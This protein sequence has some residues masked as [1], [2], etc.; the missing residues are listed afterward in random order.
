VVSLA[1]EQA[2]T[3][4]KRWQWELSS[5]YSQ[6]NNCGPTCITF[7]A[8]FYKDTASYGIETTRR[9]IN[10]MGPYNVN[11]SSVWGAPPNTP[12]NTWQQRDMLIK[13]GVG[14]E[15]RQI[16]VLSQLRD[17][18]GGGQRPILVGLLMEHVPDYIKDHSFDGWHAVVVM[19]W[20][21]RNGQSGFWIMDPNFHPPSDGYRVDPDRGRKWYP[22]WVMQKAMLDASPAPW[23]VVPLRKKDAPLTRGRGRV[24]GPGVPIRKEKAWDSANVWARSRANGYTYRESDGH[25]LWTNAHVYYYFGWDSSKKWARVATATGRR[26]YI[27]RSDFEVVRYPGS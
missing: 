8:G 13:R 23:A 22:D 14:A 9:L 15:V 18:V 24:N 10:G 6:P 27:H 16:N 5:R 11:G 20:G 21:H 19:D 12:T 2:A 7:I 3:S 4:P 25:R 26:L 17:F 1:F